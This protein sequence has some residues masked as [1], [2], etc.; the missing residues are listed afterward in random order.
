MLRLARER[1]SLDVINDQFGAPTGADLLADVTGHAIRQIR[2]GQSD[3]GLFHLAAAGH[4]TWYGYAKYVVDQ[5]KQM[6]AA[7]KII[8]TSVNPVVSAAFSTSR[9][10]T[11]KFAAEHCQT[12]TGV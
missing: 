12:P 8:A 4:T 11:T 9:Q 5:S 6:Q 7:H 3:G 1:E 2:R 10:A